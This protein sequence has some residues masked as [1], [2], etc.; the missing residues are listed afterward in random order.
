MGKIN[1]AADAEL[2][3]GIDGNASAVFD[4]F[5]GLEDFEVAAFATKA[6]E[7]GFVEKLEERLGGTVE[8]GDFDVVEV[9]EDVI[10]AIGISG[11]EKMLGGGEQDALFHEA[12][13]VTDPGDVVAVSFDGKVVEVYAAEDD[14]GVWRRGLKAEL[15]MNTRVKTHTLGLDRPLNSGLEH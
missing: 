14:A 5:D 13:G 12:S 6:A 3:G 2:V 4:D 7:A 9:D 10:D 11:G 1:V 15:G 8:D